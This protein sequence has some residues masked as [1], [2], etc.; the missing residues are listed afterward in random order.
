MRSKLFL[1]SFSFL[2][3]SVFAQEK[4]QDSLINNLSEVVITG[5]YNAQSVKKSVFQV[6]VISR[7][8]I[9]R[10][11]G[12]NLADLLNQTL[13]I[14]IIPNASSGK[15]SVQLF[16]L[17]AQYFKILV[18]N[19]P[20]INDEGLGNNT[21]LTQINLDDIQQ[22][23]IVEGSM[24]VEYGANA[25][26]GI[27]N[28][29]TKKNSKYKWEITPY[30]QE[31]TIGKEY[32]LVDRGRH[33]Q[34]L[35]VGHNFNE[36]WYANALITTNDFKGFLN[37]KKGKNHIENDGLRGYEWL[38][39]EQLNVKS[40]ISYNLKDH[41]FFYKFEF[42]K[43]TTD[44]FDSFVD[45]GHHTQTQTTRPR[46]ADEIFESERFFH[47]LN[48]TGKFNFM[49][50]DASFSFQQQKR[51][52]ETYNYWIRTGEKFDVK[53]F[54]YESRDGFYSKANFSNFLKSENV[55]FQLGYEISEINGYLSS[56][57]GL[58]QDNIDR[59]LGSYDVYGS[60]E[61]KINDKISIRPGVRAL[62][63]SQFSTQ[64]ALSLS[65]RFFLKNDYELRAIVGTSP[66]LP[67]Y[68]EMY[69][70]L[71][72]VNHNVQGNPDLN[73]E[74]GVS[75]FLHLNKISKFKSGI[76]L[77]NKFSAWYIDVKDRIEL[78][79]VNQTPLQYQY[80]NIDV[81][82]TIG[83]SFTSSLNYKNWIVNAGVTFAGV[84]KVLDSQE[85]HSDDFLY[86]FQLNANLSYRVEK[87]NTVFSAFVKY[88][89]PQY[90]FVNQENENGE[91]ILVRG[92][93]DGFTWLDATVKKSFFKN[94][95]EV[96]VGARNI[97]DITTINTTSVEGGAHSG[98]PTNILMGYGRS[99]FMKLLYKLNF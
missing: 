41:R 47:H 14:N 4:E 70:Y 93:Q 83:T 79:I 18:D 96:T 44:R 91:S 67:N 85:N 61:V 76:Q 54:E 31:E 74:Q 59:R 16:G 32:N 17:D 27:I 69:T 82:K 35:K 46:S 39:K 75:A 13:N 88:N 90:Q 63:S 3:F 89:G 81:Y 80:R 11:A 5:Q 34:S 86:G 98:P 66:R 8:D 84:S 95:F 62:F 20:I 33:I 57:A 49:N 12:N 1:L 73:P 24:G 51:N 77:S 53:N 37:D 36:K 97:L 9:D 29:I 58:F 60:T 56:I 40:L 25:V 7:E 64:T 43:E 30:I 72:D 50:Y 68:E 38:P 2:S 42:F 15:S 87:I 55:D 92:K 94:N 22:I 28:I 45:D 52:V 21:D 6:K 99:Y 19:I 65:S 23:E 78:I 26:S 48:L 10:Q 71:V